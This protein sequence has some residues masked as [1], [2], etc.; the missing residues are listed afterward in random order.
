ME[1]KIN[2]SFIKSYSK[3]YSDKV[4]NDFFSQ[5]HHINGTELLEFCKPHQIN[6]FILKEFFYKWKA[7]TSK[8]KS[9]WFDYDHEEVKVA[10]EH[11]MNILSKHILIGKEEL[12]PLLEG[13]V[14]NTILLV[15]S[16]Y[17]FYLKEFRRPGFSRVTKV[18][19]DELQK[20][21]KINA[22]LLNRFI[23]KFE[24][25]GIEAVFNDDAIRMFNEVCELSRE[26][27]EDFESY[28]SQFSEIAPL[29]ANS[30]YTNGK[31]QIDTADIPHTEEEKLH[32]K[33]VSDEQKTLLDDLTKETG[34][35]RETIADQ[36]PENAGT[37]IKNSITLNQRFMFVNELFTGN[38]DEFEIVVNTIDNCQNQ[39]EAFDF[40]RSNYIDNDTWEKDSDMVKKFF[41][42][43]SRHFIT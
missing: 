8:L 5:K 2:N 1:G 19:L 40:I 22:G 27:P 11:F 3:S 7:E 43:I 35:Q 29:Q 23:I 21:V 20:Y 31:D 34:E 18:N 12:R 42:I 15:F 24:E 13:A 10:L 36:Q 4:L 26:T 37:G 41:E 33:F 30:I 28:L 39:Q 25:D 9:P 14:E 16:P 32:A 6:L 38:M 17:E